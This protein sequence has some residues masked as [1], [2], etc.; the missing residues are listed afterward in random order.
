MNI[1]LP[2]IGAIKTGKDAEVVIPSAVK[3]PQTDMKDK[4]KFFGVLGG[5]LDISISKLSNEKSIST[6]LLDANKDWVYRNNDVI[7]QEVSAIDFEL[8][9]VGLKKGDIVY[10][11]VEEHQILDL[12]D[13]FNGT[14]TK[15]DGFYNTQSHKK[16]T[17]DAFW[18]LVKNGQTVEEI[19]VLQPD[20]VTLDIDKATDGTPTVTGYVYKDNIDGKTV[21]VRYDPDEIIHFKKPNPQNAFRGLGAVEAMSETIDTDILTNLAQKNFFKKG[22]ITNFVLTTEGKIT[23][24]QL[25]RLKAEMRANNGGAQNAFEMMILSGGLKPANIS[26]SNRDL[27]LIDLLTWY[28]DKIMVGF[29]NT[30]ASLGIIEDVNQANA[31]DTLLAWKRGTIKPDMDAIVATL[32]EFLVPLFGKNLIL[33]YVNPVPEDRTDDLTEAVM[34]KN[35]GI[36]TVNEARDVLDYEAVEGGDI[37]APNGLIDVPGSANEDETS[38][39]EKPENNDVV[40]PDDADERADKRIYRKLG[41]NQ[42]QVGKLPNSL[43]HMKDIKKLLRQRKMFMLKKHNNELREMVKPT[44]R[45]LLAEGKTKEEAEAAAA[46]EIETR[47]SPYFTNEVV[48]DFYKSQIH[49]VEVLEKQFEKAIVKFIGKIEEQVLHNFDTEISNKSQLKKYVKKDQFDLFEDEKLKT[50]AQLDLTPILMNEV[51]VA[52]QAA[53][54]LIGIND[55]YIPFNVADAVAGNVSKF[56]QSML[57]T[58]RD[59]LSSLITDGV[60]NGLSVPEIRSTITNKFEDIS[61]I[62]A[63]RITRTEVMRASNLA[64]LDAYKQS[65]VVEAKQWL[66]AGATD[67]CSAYEG[68][69]ESL[70]NNFYSSSDFA[71]GDPPLHPNCRCVLIPVVTINEGGDTAEIDADNEGGFIS[72]GGDNE[73]DGEEGV[74]WQRT[75]HGAGGAHMTSTPM[76]GNAFYVSRTESTAE[77]YGDVT[78]YNIPIA[79]SKIFMINNQ[80]EF[81]AF[82]TDV[83]NYQRDNGLANTDINY[84]IPKYVKSLGYQAAEVA[85]TFDPLGGIAIYDKKLIPTN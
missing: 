41:Y 8:Y 44:I 31:N 49:T 66:T 12:L 11:E 69:T 57:D 5:L 60:N 43:A 63:S 32:N 13:K 24:E 51:V 67:E 14:T 45:K 3:I 2:F 34:L 72:L 56:T 68:Q 40:E 9:Q 16:I 84:V 21:S 75:Y 70:D 80:E 64:N 29:G 50:Q 26:F 54:K 23:P 79:K 71:D 38:P 33:G 27:Q 22:A 85:E 42:K 74:D 37:F 48:M 55:T 65:G 18:Y 76:L 81:D 10:T 4:E 30:P 52:G 73:P 82:I 25:K 15:A 19:Y 53:Y 62:Q 61:K 36:I 6:R 83:L 59:A 17:G 46:E 77:R 20:K 78:Q 39:K 28:R 35:S 1:N 58:D 47:I 7:A